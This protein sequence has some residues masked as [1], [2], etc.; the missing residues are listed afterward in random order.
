MSSVD[1]DIYFSNFKTF[2]KDNPDELNKLIGNASDIVFFDEVYKQIHENYE[3]GDE[4]PLT[5]KQIIS[6]V[7]KINKISNKPKE[8]IQNNIFQ[9]TKFGTFCLN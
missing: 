3:G 2:F 7:V 4:L 1:I 9:E 8:E 5:H 6:I